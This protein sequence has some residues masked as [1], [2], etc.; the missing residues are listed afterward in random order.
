M[1]PDDEEVMQDEKTDE[2][3][4]YFEHVTTPKVLLLSGTKPSSKTVLLL[5]ELN[6]CIPNSEF[7]CVCVCVCVCVWG[8]VGGWVG[9][10]VGGWVCVWGS[11]CT[12]LPQGLNFSAVR[13]F[14]TKNLVQYIHMV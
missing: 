3:A 11:M 12:L 6:N 2:F 7:R 10:C 14:G 8:W 1:V 9:V 13:N 4:A 5:R